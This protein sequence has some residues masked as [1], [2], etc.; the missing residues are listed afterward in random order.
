MTVSVSGFPTSSFPSTLQ[1]DVEGSPVLE[2]SFQRAV[3]SPAIRI[4]LSHGQA[5]GSA[6]PPIKLA[7]PIR[8]Y[9][10]Q[11]S[12]GVCLAFLVKSAWVCSGKP[13]IAKIDGDMQG[14]GFSGNVVQT[15]GFAGLFRSR[16]QAK[17][18]ATELLPGFLT[19]TGAAQLEDGTSYVVA[20]VYSTTVAQ[21]VGEPAGKFNLL[22][23]IPIVTAVFCFGALLLFWW[24]KIRQNKESD[25]PEKLKHSPSGSLSKDGLLHED[26]ASD[27]N[28]NTVVVHDGVPD[29]KLFSDLEISSSS[30]MI[31]SNGMDEGDSD[32]DTERALLSQ[33]Q[34]NMA[35][36]PVPEGMFTEDEGVGV[37]EE[38]SVEELLNTMRS[39]VKLREISARELRLG[40]TIGEGSYKIVHQGWY[41]KEGS[42]RA[43]EVA[44]SAIRFVGEH[45]M[46]DVKKK[47]L[48]LQQTKDFMHEAEVALKLGKHPFIITLEGVCFDRVTDIPHISQLPL[49]TP[50]DPAVI[51]Y[52]FNA[53][54]EKIL[55]YGTLTPG[56]LPDVG[57]GPERQISAPLDQDQPFDVK[58]ANFG[59]H[60][61]LLGLNFVTELC[62]GSLYDVMYVQRKSLSIRDKKRIVFETISGL[63]H[64]H[65]QKMIHRDLKTHNILMS[66]DM[67]ARICDFGTVKLRKFNNLSTSGQGL[68][69]PGYMA[70]EQW[71][72]NGGSVR[73]SSPAY[74]RLQQFGHVT[75]K[76]DIWAFGCVVVELFV[77]K[78]PWSKRVKMQQRAHEKD[79]IPPEVD[80]FFQTCKDSE[81]KD[82][83][84]ACLNFDPTLRWSAH[85]ILVELEHLG[86][87]ERDDQANTFL[88]PF[89]SQEEGGPGVSL[90]SLLSPVLPSFGSSTGTSTMN[91][92]RPT[93][94]ITS[95][96]SSQIATSAIATSWNPSPGETSPETKNNTMPFFS[97]PS[98]QSSGNLRSI[99]H[100]RSNS[101]RSTGA[102]HN[103]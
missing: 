77:E 69:T 31:E 65:A 20:M 64:L 81:I 7:F 24:R 87:G 84:A 59:P 95:N 97:A 18:I 67:S 92:R 34:Q 48:I 33:Q 60:G 5:D 37:E 17:S 49:P 30:S 94:Q 66:K 8:L 89:S 32:Y 52:P 53:H 98:N 1:V 10:D 4:M 41:E 14:I 15:L 44:I 85:Q 73:R 56:Q 50:R 93:P 6:L 58:L 63:S 68:G 75:E 91:E 55:S 45:H 13:V 22:F 102:G 23:L 100:M 79:F 80:D 54:E 57:F 83:V 29:D 16:R 103:T 43:I 70:P 72:V 35:H 25:S 90:P 76:S 38:V 19:A 78:P 40:D 11:D 46:N 96:E 61:I 51:G 36:L 88:D 74:K 28:E 9:P 26:Q 3:V 101:Q 86:W 12:K 82:I 27:S 21:L 42:D 47:N 39:M 99:R 62:V 71:L 2:T